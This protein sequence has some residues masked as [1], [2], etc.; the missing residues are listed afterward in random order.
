[1]PKDGEIADPVKLS[2]G[3]SEVARKFNDR[4]TWLVDVVSLQHRLLCGDWPGRLTKGSAGNAAQK[5]SGAMYCAG[6][7]TRGFGAGLLGALVN[8]R[9]S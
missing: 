4:Y 1:M 3:F 7:L 8:V 2:R 5:G 6:C 9:Q